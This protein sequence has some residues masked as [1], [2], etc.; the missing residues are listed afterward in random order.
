MPVSGR[1][2][3]REGFTLIELLVVIAIIAI[4]AGMLLPALAKAKDRALNA[5]D[6]S[7]CKQIMLSTHMFAT[8]NQDDLPSPSWGLVNGDPEYTS[9]AYIGKVNGVNMPDGAGDG[10]APFTAGS[11][12]LAQVEYFNQGQL[13]RYL[14]T[15]KVLFCP[16]DMAEVGGVKKT[17]WSQRSVKL[18]SYTFNGCII[19]NGTYA[20]WEK[21]KARKQTQ[22]RPQD[23]LFWETA[24]SRPFYFNDAGNQP[25]EG[26]SQRHKANKYKREVIKEDWGGQSGMGRMDGS[27]NFI[28][29]R[30]FM[31]FAGTTPDGAPTGIPGFRAIPPASDQN[32]LWIG[33]AYKR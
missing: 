24:E 25:I 29:F 20:G 31:E 14:T 21:G 22:F 33:P 18:T 8:D 16:K 27:A 7:G 6:L 9:W 17:E 4:L 2:T 28:R 11:K 12:S 23:I 26:I 10:R 30:Q 32:D 3:P 15:P 19:D 5:V 1:Q 13:G